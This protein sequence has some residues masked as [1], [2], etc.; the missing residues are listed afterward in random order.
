M[1]DEYD[2]TAKKTTS[3][4]GLGFASYMYDSDSSDEGIRRKHSK[5]KALLTPLELPFPTKSFPAEAVS[6]SD[7]IAGSHVAE[8]ASVN[9]TT[10]NDMLEDRESW[11]LVQLPTRLP[12]LQKRFADN[13]HSDGE[14]PDV[15]EI[16]APMSSTDANNAGAISEVI[17]P[18][19]M[20]SS[21]DNI[22]ETVAPGRIGKIL[23]YKSGKTVLLID[24]DE[25]NE[26]SDD[27]FG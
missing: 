21:F 17:T 7:R 19:V 23:V 15:Q 16:E 27:W 14:D 9:A 11:F 4:S 10:T 5:S 20:T 6:S 25:G 2:E 8:E 18:P 1:D 3:G 13:N 24:G 26:V 22:L 12:P